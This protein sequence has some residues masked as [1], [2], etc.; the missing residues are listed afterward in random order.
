MKT[1][2]IISNQ[3]I[4]AFREAANKIQVNVSA[5]ESKP[6]TTE[7]DVHYTHPHE[8]YS[9]GII[10][11]AMQ[12]TNKILNKWEEERR[13]QE[14][15]DNAKLPIFKFKKEDLVKISGHESNHHF[16]DGEIVEII[17]RELDNGLGIKNKPSYNCKSESGKKWFVWEE[18]LTDAKLPELEENILRE[19]I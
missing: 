9:L 14:V 8:L 15:L 10:Q 5:L 2:L 11:S 6:N 17:E 18:D 19:K 1:T 7:F 4:I 13:F 16:D 12:E 3:N